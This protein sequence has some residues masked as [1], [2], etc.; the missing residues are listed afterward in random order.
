MS[1]SFGVTSGGATTSGPGPIS[2]ERARLVSAARTSGVAFF[3]GASARLG[4][5]LGLGFFG[6]VVVAR[7]VVARVVVARVVVSGGGGGLA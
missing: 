4:C 6:V 2:L 3:T 7:V 1:V 5:T